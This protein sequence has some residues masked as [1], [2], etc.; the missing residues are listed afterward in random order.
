MHTPRL[1]LLLLAAGLC[2]GAA[3]AAGLDASGLAD[4]AGL[5]LSAFSAESPVEATADRMGADRATGALTLTGNVRIRFAD[6]TLRCDE[7]SYN[8]LTG[9]VSARGDVRIDS[10]SGGS[11]H[12]DRI[13]FNAKTG[14]GLVGT[15]LLRLGAFSVDAPGGVARDADGVFHGREVTL[16]TCANEQDAWHWSVTG[17]GR[18]KDREFVELRN[19]VGRVFGL[20]VV[21]M[22]YYYRDLNTRYGWRVTPGYTGK[23]GAYLSLGYVYPIAG[24]AEQDAFLYGKSQLDL[25]SERGV[26]AGQEL[27][28]CSDGFLGEGTRQ[29]GRLSLYYA[30]DTEDQ[31]SEDLNWQSSYD[32]SRWSI[33]LTERLDFTPRD[34]LSITGETVSDSMF[35]EDYNETGVRASSQPLGIANYE[36]RENAWVASLALMGPIDSFY[37]GTRRLPELRLDTLP[38]TLFGIPRLYYESQTAIGWLRRQPAK[39]DSTWDERFRWQPGNWAYYDTLRVDTRHILRRPFTLAEGITLT[40]RLGWRGT[41]YT[42]AP[43][44]SSLFRSR[45]EIGATLQGRWWADFRNLR[46]TVIPYLDL[47]Y[48]PASE[49]DPDDVPYAFDRLDQEYEWRDRFASDGLTPSHRYAGLRFGLRNLLQRRD[50][51]GILS[52]LLNADLYG[53]Y[54]FQTQDHWVRWWHRDQPGRDNLSRRARRVKEEDGLRVIGLNAAYAP[55]DDIEIATDIQFDPEESRLAFWDIALRYDLHPLTLYVGYLRRNHEIYDTYW[56]DAV[57]DAVAYGGF[58]HKLSDLIE[59]S[60]YLRY[61]TE[62]AD[63]EEIGGFVQY[64]LDC[65]ALRVN[66]GYLPSYTTEDGWDHDSDFRISLGAWLRAF[67]HREDEEWMDWAHLP[68]DLKN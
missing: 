49:D 40:P 60:L 13:D 7:A 63:L 39:Y 32:H 59:W 56:A 46:H 36:H 2:A 57:K 64:N 19:A 33:G 34:F 29:W 4:R 9:D 41:Y 55:F 65:V 15:G 43:D 61:N 66:L 51:E 45:F 20:P 42:D 62:E 22:P 26:G 48:V 37:A 16:T 58:I 50:R 1:A 5:D 52:T 10:A 11:W 6:A 14:E 12:G 67:P 53:V 35:R 30:Y 21:W 18:Y 47:S 31:G 28:W 8:R 17:T 3:P 27:T 68:R 44:G 25:R 24:G 54:V 23:W 38:R